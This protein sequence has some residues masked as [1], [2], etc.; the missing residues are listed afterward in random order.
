MYQRLGHEQR[1][2]YPEAIGQPSM[3]SRHGCDPVPSER[4]EAG[5][6][7]RLRLLVE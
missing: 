5:L 7:N 6:C 4:I 1:M 3:V 2:P